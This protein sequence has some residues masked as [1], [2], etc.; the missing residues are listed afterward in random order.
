M[1][2]ELKNIWN[3][4]GYRDLSLTLVDPQTKREY[5]LHIPVKDMQRL[6]NACADAVKQIGAPHPPIDWDRYPTKIYWPQVTPWVDGKRPATAAK[7]GGPTV[8]DPNRPY[9]KPV[10]SCCD[11]ACG[12]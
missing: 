3:G 10:Q 7:G 11:F 4:P 5:D 12:N 6:I 9:C 8:D 2:L 1:K